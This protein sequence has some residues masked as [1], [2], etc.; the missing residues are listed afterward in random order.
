MNKKRRGRC[1]ITG[2]RFPLKT[3]TTLRG[4]TR[5]CPGGCFLIEEQMRVQCQ[6]LLKDHLNYLTIFLGTDKIN[7]YIFQFFNLKFLSL[8]QY[9][10]TF[11]TMYQ[12]T[13]L[14]HDTSS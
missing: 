10:E 3:D 4:R 5:S 8:A 7:M 12:P 1:R 13:C 14:K 2:Q 9:I 11:V 6:M